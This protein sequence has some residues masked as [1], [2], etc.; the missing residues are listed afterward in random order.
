MAEK[1]AKSSLIESFCKS[2]GYEPSD[3]IGANTTTR[4]VVTANG[5]KYQVSS[6]GRVRNIIG[7]EAPGRKSD[8]E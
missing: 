5:G 7:P 8:D 3:V 4:T 2:T 6:K 1:S